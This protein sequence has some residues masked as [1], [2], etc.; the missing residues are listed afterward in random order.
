VLVR[1]VT[2]DE[3]GSYRTDCVE[4]SFVRARS[5]QEL[6]AGGNW[7]DVSTSIKSALVEPY[8]S[9][10][11]AS[12][13]K[14]TNRFHTIRKYHKQ[15]VLPV[16]F[17]APLFTEANPCVP[18]CTPVYPCVPLCTPAPCVQYRC[19]P[20]CT[21]VYPCVP[22]CIPAPPYQVCL[23]S[24]RSPARDANLRRLSSS[25]RSAREGGVLTAPLI[26]IASVRAGGCGA[27]LR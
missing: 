20:L 19:V 22:S 5:A 3:G 15:G 6:S 9:E 17:A 23:S 4:L 21:P 16:C 1:R 13:Y 11:T 10:T 27:A 14:V 2:D 25:D 24:Q 8:V 12:Q 7:L 18:L 26:V